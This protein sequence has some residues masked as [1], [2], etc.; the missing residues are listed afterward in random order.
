MSETVPIW[1]QVTT[2]VGQISRAAAIQLVQQRLSET[3]KHYKEL[4]TRGAKFYVTDACVHDVSCSTIRHIFQAEHLW[5]WVDTDSSTTDIER[6]YRAVVVDDHGVRSD[7][8]RFVVEVDDPL[9]TGKR[10]CALWAPDIYPPAKKPRV[11]T[12]AAS[13][14]SGT[15]LGRAYEGSP[16]ISIEHNTTAVTIRTADGS[17]RA[18]SDPCARIALR[19]DP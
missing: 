1:S 13:S 10:R 5:C 6:A 18:F 16:V 2:P 17:T 4:V 3:P 12:K 11:L 9:L 7:P 15:D 19:V 14:L 8:H